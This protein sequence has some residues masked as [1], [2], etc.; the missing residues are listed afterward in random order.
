[1]HECREFYNSMFHFIQF[2]FPHESRR[3]YFLRFFL[4]FI[5]WKHLNGFDTTGGEREEGKKI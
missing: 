2:S 3:E 1:M 4:F 5:E